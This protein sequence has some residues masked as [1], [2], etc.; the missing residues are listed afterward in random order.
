MSFVVMRN[1]EPKVICVKRSSGSPILDEAAIAIVSMG[2]Y[3]P[4]TAKVF[5]GE[6]GHPFA[7]TIEFRPPS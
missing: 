2:H 6:A 1:G 5:A 4:M 3:P 7:V